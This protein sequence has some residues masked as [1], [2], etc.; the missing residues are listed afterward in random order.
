MPYSTLVYRSLENRSKQISSSPRNQVQ[1]G[2][3]VRHMHCRTAIQQRHALIWTPQT[4]KDP[5]SRHLSSVPRELSTKAES[6]K[7]REPVLRHNLSSTSFY[8]IVLQD[9]GGGFKYPGYAP[10][11]LPTQ[12]LRLRG[13]AALRVGTG[14]ENNT[15]CP[16]EL[17]SIYPATT[18]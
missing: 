9:D 6:M 8:V 1:V 12:L 4:L 2:H 10:C 16:L 5:R 3:A 14:Y 13:L 17:R 15:Y 11:A 7:T 18:S